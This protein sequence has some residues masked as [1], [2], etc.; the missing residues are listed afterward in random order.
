MSRPRPQADQLDQI[1]KALGTPSETIYPGI[2]E[3]P[4]YKPD[5][6]KSYPRPESLAHLVPGLPEAGVDLLTRMLQ[7]DPAKRITAKDAMDHAFFAD[8]APHV[9]AGGIM[10]VPFAKSGTAG[11]T[12]AGGSGG[13]AGAAA[14]GAGIVAGFGGGVA[15]GGGS[16]A[17]A[18]VGAGFG[19]VGAA[20]AVPATAIAGAGRS[21]MGGF[22]AVAGAPAAAVGGFGGM[23]K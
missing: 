9:K 17:T 20:A 18:G 5:T 16:G 6:Y 21:T 19:G 23:H 13:G 3:L 7:F 11:T 2:V 10:G 14:G 1:F 22:G 4:D 8:L 12:A 15:A